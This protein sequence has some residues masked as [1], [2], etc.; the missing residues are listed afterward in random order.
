[1]SSEA[2]GIVPP[3]YVRNG[4]DWAE[5][6]SGVL[7][8]D[9]P[10]SAEVCPDGLILPLRRRDEATMNRGNGVFEG[11]ACN[12]EG[13]F[14]GGHAR[15]GEAWENLNCMQAYEVDPA[16]IRNSDE[17][18]IYCGVMYKHFGH[19]LVDSITRYWYLSPETMAGRKLAFTFAPTFGPSFPKAWKVL[20]SH[21]GASPD[22]V[23]FVEEPTR[24]A[25]VVVPQESFAI[26]VGG[27]LATGDVFRA[28]RDGVVPGSFDKVFLSRGKFNR[29]D[30]INESFLEDF[31]VRRGYQ[32]VYPERLPFEEQVSILAGASEIASTVGTMSHL[33][34]FFARDDAKITFFTRAGDV[35]VE[36]LVVDA[37]CGRRPNYVDAVRSPLPTKN[38]SYAYLFG[39]TRF[40]RAYLDDEGIPYDESELASDKLSDQDIVAFL[41]RYDEAAQ[42]D[43]NEVQK[44]LRGLDM[45]DLLSALHEGLCDVDSPREDYLKASAIQ[46]EKDRKFQEEQSRVEVLSCSYGDDLLVLRL[47]GPRVIKDEPFKIVMVNQA[48]RERREIPQQLDFEDDGTVA[49]VKLDV[50]SFFEDLRSAS[51]A[52]ERWDL[53][54]EAPGLSVHL[55]TQEGTTPFINFMSFFLQAEGKTLAPHVCG[56]G[57]LSL[58]YLGE[59]R[60]DFSQDFFDTNEGKPLMSV[61]LRRIIKE[62]DY[63]VIPLLHE[64]FVSGRVPARKI[65]CAPWGD[66]SVVYRGRIYRVG[67]FAYLQ[68]C[69]LKFSRKKK[70]K[71]RHLLGRIYRRLR[72]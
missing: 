66:K 18:V 17:K 50:P 47:R 16:N 39:P 38:N 57:F 34:S 2:S 20:L 15:S 68:A 25:E 53:F 27:N 59:R 7:I 35:V 58:W 41:R 1:M 45:A 32:V 4:R 62:E 40:F 52:C 28:T 51:S 42:K 70:S 8:S 29:H 69:E 44:W 26:L 13:H 55:K 65:P 11:G 10:L 37:L 21:L 54:A 3:F 24:F 72:H 30:C 22:D 46:V 63:E 48:A 36:Q 71:I 12:A 31:Y 43:E 5:A 6:Q 67:Y 23:I 14:V 60:N 64:D 33:A 61:L 49:R 9:E 56:P 19:M